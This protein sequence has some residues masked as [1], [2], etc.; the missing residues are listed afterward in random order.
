[1]YNNNIQIITEYNNQVYEYITN[2]D[3][4]LIL[5]LQVG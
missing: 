3:D 5:L 2:I 1:M 4:I